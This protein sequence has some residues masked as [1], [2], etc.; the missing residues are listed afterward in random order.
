MTVSVPIKQEYRTGQA[1]HNHTHELQKKIAI[2]EVQL[3][4]EENR[5]NTAEVDR[6]AWKNQAQLLARPW[7]KKLNG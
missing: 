6:D 7:W 1:P 2:L 4:A 3:K 5:A